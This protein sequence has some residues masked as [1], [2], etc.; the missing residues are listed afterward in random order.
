MLIC[1]AM[2][3]DSLHMELRN[4]FSSSAGSPQGK[5]LTIPFLTDLDTR[6]AIKG[7]RDPLG[8]QSIWT[9][10]GR[11]VVGNLTTVSDSIRDFTTLLLGYF[12]AGR[13]ADEGN[14][15]SELAIFLRWEQL[16]A[17][18]RAAVNTERGFRGTERVWRNL[19]ERKPR[20]V[21]ISDDRAQQILGNQKIYG[22]W[23]LYTMPARASGLLDGDPTRLTP[24]ALEMVETFYLPAMRDGGGRDAQR[25]MEALRPRSRRLDVD[26]SDLRLLTAVARVLQS[27]ILPRERDFYRTYL[28]Y[29]GPHDK[30]GGLQ[31][32]MAAL[33]EG[34]PNI[35][36]FRW[37]PTTI[38]ALAKEAQTQG[39]AELADR[40]ERIR[41]AESVLA[42]MSLLF[43]HLLG[44][45]G[46]LADDVLGRLR[47]A[48]GSEV[49]TVDLEAF[50][51][52]RTEIGADTPD[53]GDRWVAIAAAFRQGRYAEL[54][55]LLIEQNGW[56]M[57]R[58]GGAS[59]IEKRDGRFC[60]RF[61][62]EQGELPDR[63]ALADLW[64]FPY[65][66]DSLRN[67]AA[68]LRENEGG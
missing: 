2:V 50:S 43:S 41:T 32:Q 46:K 56:V 26:G 61:R 38:T 10:F 39:M 24:P 5:M 27:R 23:G 13:L 15:G 62:D 60:V 18:A 68:K 19:D 20:R 42:P 8:I 31:R 44:M 37:R 21:V 9:R 36:D 67:V 54:V 66:L 64:R 58:R 52:L 28:L 63:K 11:H 17:Y 3:D 22:L 16:A 57:S 25:I 48:W 51:L 30:T 59:W 6:A 34:T 45:D 7:S 33:F 49:A 47:T 1:I 65:F 55:D 4:R 12:L 14:A 53:V 35:S 29:G 40:L